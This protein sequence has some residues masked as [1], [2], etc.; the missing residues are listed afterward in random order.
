M[1]AATAMV[2]AFTASNRLPG[3]RNAANAAGVLIVC[4]MLCFLTY[5]FCERLFSRD[6]QMNILFD[7]SILGESLMLGAMMFLTWMRF[8]TVIPLGK[9]GLDTR[10]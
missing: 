8:L 3:S 2:A 1:I 7:Q 5:S 9:S 4:F 6:W 10:R